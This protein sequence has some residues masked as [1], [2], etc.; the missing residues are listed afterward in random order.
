[1]VKRKMN[2]HDIIAEKMVRLNSNGVSSLNIVKM[3]HEHSIN[4]EVADSLAIA[5]ALDF[6]AN[7]LMNDLR[8][9]KQLKDAG[10]EDG[11]ADSFRNLTMTESSRRDRVKRGI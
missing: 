3:F 7:F 9:A 4:Q 5:C 2:L 6:Y 11:F 10:D 8:R 1:M